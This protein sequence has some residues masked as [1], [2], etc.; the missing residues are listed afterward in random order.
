MNI[1]PESTQNSQ[2]QMLTWFLS[3]KSLGLEHD[4]E[5]AVH[6]VANNIAEGYS[7]LDRGLA[8]NFSD[9]IE[10]SPFLKAEYQVE[11]KD[12]EYLAPVV[13]LGDWV[14]SEVADHVSD[15]MIHGSIATL[16][17]SRGWSD[18]DT[19]VIVSTA[20]ATNGRALTDLRTKLLGA[21]EYLTR[22]DP[23][24][25]H[26]FLVCTEIDL[27]RYNE[28]IMP[29]VVLQNAKSYFGAITH[30]INPVID[31]DGDRKTLAARAAFFREAAES[32]VMEHHAYEGVYLQGH[33]QNAE[34]GLFQ[35]KYLLGNAALAP[36]YYAGSAGEPAYKSN[37]IQLVRPLLSTASRSFLDSTT[38]VR[39]EWPEREAFPY[40][41]NSIP[42]WVQEIVDPDYIA[43]LANLLGELE[44][45]AGGAA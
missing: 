8:E 28:S 2:R 21:Y 22:V 23:L 7:N 40:E 18:F 36:C 17:Y 41:G 30:K 9:E 11:A 15:F 34:N 39:N 13:E 1:P 33:Y 14:N 38:Q 12:Q 24:Q 6:M 35:L 19:F 20:T 25:H 42:G 27:R 4:G 16:D 45:L 32:D 26:G 31:A 29:L 3:P 44:N 37:A 43:N 5:H 10:I